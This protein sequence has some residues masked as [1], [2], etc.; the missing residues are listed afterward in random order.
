MIVHAVIDNG[1]YTAC[2]A[3]ATIL[4]HIYGGGGHLGDERRWEISPSHPIDTYTLYYES[5]G[6]QM[7]P[8]C[9]EAT[10]TQ[11]VMETMREMS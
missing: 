9:K 8:Q 4:P 1:L 3:P 11:Y 10:Y 5:Q 7:C 6:H 2:G